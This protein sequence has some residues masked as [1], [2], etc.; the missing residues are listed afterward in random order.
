MLYPDIQPYMTGLLPVSAL[1]TI[2]YEQ[3]GNPDGVPV[4]FLHGGPGGGIDPVYRQF[5]NPEK[6][7]VVLFD[8]REFDEI[9]KEQKGEQVSLWT[10]NQG[11]V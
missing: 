11:R 6:W 9:K 8:Q 4:V 1:H 3:V 7:R 5:F 2:Y 10:A